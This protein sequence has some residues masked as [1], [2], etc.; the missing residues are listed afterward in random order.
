MKNKKWILDDLIRGGCSFGFLVV[1]Y[2]YGKVILTCREREYT[3]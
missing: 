2:S 3:F 1:D